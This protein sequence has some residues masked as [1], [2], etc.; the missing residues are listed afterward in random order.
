VPLICGNVGKLSQVVLNILNNAI[1][2]VDSME[3]PARRTITLTTETLTRDGTPH[4]A[5]HVAD[6]GPGIEPG[7]QG[8]I[9]DPF[10]TTKPVGRVYG[11]R[12]FHLRQSDPGAPWR[13]GGFQRPRTGGHLFH[14]VAR[15]PG[16]HSMSPLSKYKKPIMLYVDDEPDNL[17]SFQALFRRD[18]TIRLAESADEALAILRNEEIHVL[19]TDQRMP[20][21]SG[22]ALL[23]QVAR[24]S[25]ASCATC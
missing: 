15:Q 2:A 25:R 18:Y 24:N 10:F 4:A 13:P 8:R 5:L 20:H 16:G 22:A 12:T 14:P 21:V 9:F 23:E 11:P 6:A 1:D 7:I 17:A 3:D 19:V